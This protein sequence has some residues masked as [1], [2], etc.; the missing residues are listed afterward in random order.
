MSR[1]RSKLHRYVTDQNDLQD[2]EGLGFSL[3][4]KDGRQDFWLGGGSEDFRAIRCQ[5]VSTM[6]GKLTAQ[7]RE[8]HRTHFLRS[9]LSAT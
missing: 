5:Q 4:V 8:T 2:S 7:A 3:T 1:V 9:S 6:Y